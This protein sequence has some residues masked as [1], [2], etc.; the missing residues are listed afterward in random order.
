MLL[1]YVTTI[2]T[3][4]PEFDFH[5]VEIIMS[6]FLPKDTEIQNIEP[7]KNEWWKWM[8]WSETITKHDLFFPITEII[9]SGFTEVRQFKKG[10]EIDN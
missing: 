9:N 7:D 8:A 3:I 2:N 6:L 5:F 1:K 10:I 4:R